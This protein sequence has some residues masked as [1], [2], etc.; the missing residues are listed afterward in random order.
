MRE[1]C[2]W[3]FAQWKKLLMWSQVIR[4]FPFLMIFWCFFGV[5]QFRQFQFTSFKQKLH[6]FLKG[7]CIWRAMCA[8]YPI[9]VCERNQK[10]HGNCPNLT[11]WCLVFI[12]VTDNRPS[13]F[14]ERVQFSAF[15]VAQW[16]W[17]R[18]V[19]WWVQWWWGQDVRRRHQTALPALC[20][21]GALP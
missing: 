6:H 1:P 9:M 19:E 8:Y 5:F 13:I 14:V 3:F 11:F 17:R 4:R 12:R 20:P 16:I 7:S 2:P 21:N 10:E 15:R 18:V